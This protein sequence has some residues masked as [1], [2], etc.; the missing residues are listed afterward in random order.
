MPAIWFYPVISKIKYSGYV[1][2]RLKFTAFLQIMHEF[3]CFAANQLFRM[4]LYYTFVKNARKTLKILRC[5]FSCG[6]CS[7]FCITPP[8]MQKQLHPP[9]FSANS[10]LLFTASPFQ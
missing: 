3:F 9:A 6:Y 5:Q 7:R 4:Q 1:F 8:M 10:T 2:W